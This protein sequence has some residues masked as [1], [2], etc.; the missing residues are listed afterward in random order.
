MTV[1]KIGEKTANGFA[2]EKNR[3]RTDGLQ[4]TARGAPVGFPYATTTNPGGKKKG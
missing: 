4:K 2:A 3:P 1:P